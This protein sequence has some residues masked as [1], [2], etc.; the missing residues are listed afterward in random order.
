MKLSLN[1]LELTV[2]L[3]LPEG[4]ELPAQVQDVKKTGTVLVKKINSFTV[5]LADSVEYLQRLREKGLPMHGADAFMEMKDAKTLTAP[6]TGVHRDNPDFSG[7]V[8][9]E[10]PLELIPGFAYELQIDDAYETV[11]AFFNGKPVGVRVQGPFRFDIP[12][13]LVKEENL[14]RIEAATLADRKARKVSPGS[15]RSMS[16]DRPFTASGIVGEVRILR[17]EA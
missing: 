15:M 7:Y 6:F 1:P 12:S 13:E 14:L 4:D 3:F 17:A 16:A 5:S 8:I 2:L 10:T 11:E 9:Y